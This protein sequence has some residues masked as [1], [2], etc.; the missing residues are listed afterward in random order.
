MCADMPH[1]FL[2][3][4]LDKMYGYKLAPLL[5]AGI[6]VLIYSGDQD[7]ICNWRGGLAWTL[8]LKWQG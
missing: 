2:I 6:P 4:D 1:T 3:F 5:D 8:A 7:Y